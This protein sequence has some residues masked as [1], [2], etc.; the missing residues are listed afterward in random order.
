MNVE[1]MIRRLRGKNYT[2]TRVNAD[3]E[4]SEVDGSFVPGETIS[5]Q[6]LGSVQPIQARDLVTIPE[7]DRVRERFRFYSLHRLLNDRVSKLRKGD[8]IAINCE[9]FRVESVQ[10]WPNYSM[11]IV[12]R[13]NTNAN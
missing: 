10:H 3:G 7:G 5:L 12:V 9:A 13:V 1:S 11:A 6:I 2:V 8:D 4:I